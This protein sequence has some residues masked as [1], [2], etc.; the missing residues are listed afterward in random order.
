MPTKV[1]Y[2]LAKHLSPKT[3]FS[4]NIPKDEFDENCFP[5]WYE[6]KTTSDK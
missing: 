1:S 3:E 4:I 6:E 2:T 5:L